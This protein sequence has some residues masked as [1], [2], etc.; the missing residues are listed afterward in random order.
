MFVLNVQ[1]FLAYLQSLQPS[2]LSNFRTSASSQEGSSHPVC[3]HSLFSATGL[4]NCKSTLCLSRFER[5]YVLTNITRIP[6]GAPILWLPG[7]QRSRRNC[8]KPEGPVFHEAEV[9]CGNI[10]PQFMP[11]LIPYVHSAKSLPFYWWEKRRQEKGVGKTES[12][13]KAMTVVGSSQETS[14][15]PF[16]HCSKA[17]FADCHCTSAEHHWMGEYVQITQQLIFL[18]CISRSGDCLNRFP[19][20]AL[21][22][23]IKEQQWQVFGN[24]IWN[25]PPTERS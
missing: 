22:S 1:S 23:E 2:P 15:D 7:L 4:G 5:P 21:E 20:M 24:C 8:L 19:R 9:I 3:G 12:G 25:W 14:V 18:W 11:P 6:G 17:G 10:S 16:A 13:R